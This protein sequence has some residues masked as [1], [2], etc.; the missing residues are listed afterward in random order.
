MKNEV[1]KKGEN[2]QIVDTVLTPAALKFLK[3]LQENDNEAIEKKQKTIADTLVA[4]IYRGYIHEPLNAKEL[5]LLSN[6]SIDY[7]HLEEFKT[8]ETN[9]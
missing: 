8:T 3:E 7:L 9:Y 5:E 2:Y 1:F 4:M 6:L